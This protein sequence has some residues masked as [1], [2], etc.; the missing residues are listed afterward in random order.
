ML[1]EE[2][3]TSASTSDSDSTQVTEEEEGERKEVI[4]IEL[5]KSE[6][7]SLR[8]DVSWKVRDEEE[9]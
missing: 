8:K 2:E 5:S 3:E 7:Q 1:E 9:E 6:E 4:P